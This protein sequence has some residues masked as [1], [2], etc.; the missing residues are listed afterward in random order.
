M[1]NKVLWTWNFW[2]V[3]IKTKISEF[4]QIFFVKRGKKHWVWVGTE[5]AK[6]KLIKGDKKNQTA[7]TFS[8]VYFLTS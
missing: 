4:R 1:T 6:K 8:E 5:K 7:Y 3:N 2:K